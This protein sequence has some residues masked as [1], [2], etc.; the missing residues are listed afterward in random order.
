[1]ITNLYLVSGVLLRLRRTTDMAGLGGIYREPA[2]V[3]GAGDGADLLPGRGSPVVGFS[4]E[5]RDCR[6]NVYRGRIL[7]GGKVLGVGLLTLLSMAR[8]WAEVSGS[9]P[10]SRDLTTPGAPL[11]VAIA[12]LS[13]VTLAMRSAQGRCSSSRSAPRNSCSIGTSTCARCSEA[14]LNVA[15]QHLLALA[16]AALQGEVTLDNLLAAAPLGTPSWRYW[17]RAA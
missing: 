11:L 15:R 8:T 1:M 5:A 13:A 12:G 9:R 6:G 10:R 7:G 17:R 14:H 4:R 3:L 2:A 16:W